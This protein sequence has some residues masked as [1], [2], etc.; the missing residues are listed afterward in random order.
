M[1]LLFDKIDRLVMI[2]KHSSWVISWVLDAA[3]MLEPT[4][5]YLSF[6]ELSLS[7]SGY[8]DYGL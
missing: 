4:A 3:S 6:V 2:I 8:A 5:Y 7:R 1:Y